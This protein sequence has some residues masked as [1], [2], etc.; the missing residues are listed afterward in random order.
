M[1]VVFE[2]AKRAGYYDVQALKEEALRFS[3]DDDVPVP[4]VSQ[5]GYSQ[6]PPSIDLHHQK[7]FGPTGG[8]VDGDY[9]GDFNDTSNQDPETQD[10]PSLSAS[11][12]TT[13]SSASVNSSAAAA[14]LDATLVSQIARHWYP[15]TLKGFAQALER[16]RK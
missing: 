8:Y 3:S 4:E 6:G 11:I 15:S 10:I 13:A 5:V 9:D 2:E 12:C 7:S 16:D 14:E 1:D